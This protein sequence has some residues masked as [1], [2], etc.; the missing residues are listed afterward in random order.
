MHFLVAF[1]GGLGLYWGFYYSGLVFRSKSSNRLINIAWVFGAVLLWALA[2]ELFEYKNGLTQSTEGYYLDTLN[3][4][5]LGAMGGLLAAILSS[6][7]G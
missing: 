6:R 2:W 5:V 3:D 7:H 4:L 1:T